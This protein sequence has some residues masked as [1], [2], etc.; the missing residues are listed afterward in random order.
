[1]APEKTSVFTGS[2]SAWILNMMACTTPTA[3]IACSASQ[4]PVPR[5]GAASLSWLLV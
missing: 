2:S 1:M 4:V 3:S 5:P